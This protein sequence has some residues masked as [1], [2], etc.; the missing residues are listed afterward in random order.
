MSMDIAWQY[1]FTKFKNKIRER[2]I[3]F[4]D[5]F[6][7][8]GSY[9]ARNSIDAA[10]YLSVPFYECWDLLQKQMESGGNA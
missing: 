3:A 9:W 10:F 2:F 6:P 5:S 7:I 4:G 1:R 8:Y